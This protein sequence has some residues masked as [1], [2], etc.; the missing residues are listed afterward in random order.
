MHFII[1]KS[2]WLRC[3]KQDHKM[4]YSGLLMNGK[5][6]CL[7]F[8]AKQL[9]VPNEELSKACLPDEITLPI[10]TA[11]LMGYFINEYNNLNNTL[12]LCAADIN[13]N[14]KTNDEEKIKLLTELFEFNGHT[15]EFVK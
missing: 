1:E 15:I 3:P 4:E 6:C 7:G 2:K 12:S 8:C 5:M 10:Y 9:G 14:Y 11:L 13:D